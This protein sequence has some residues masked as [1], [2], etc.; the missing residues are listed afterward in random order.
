M[1]NLIKMDLY[2]LVR[3]AS[4]WVILCAA[5]GLAVFSNV[6]TG[7][8]LSAIEE[9]QTEAAKQ[10]GGEEA[11]AMEEAQTDGEKNADG[12]TKAGESAAGE[13]GEAGAEPAE[14]TP[15]ES[16]QKQLGLYVSTPEEWAKT[17]IQAGDLALLNLQSGLLLV[18]CSVLV[19]LFVNAEQKNGYIKNIAGQLKNRGSL[20]VSHMAVTALYLAAVL[21]L[22]VL[23]IFL[24]GRAVF[25]ERLLWEASDSFLMGIFAQYLLHL[26]F[27][28]L[29][30]L[31]GTL[32][33]SSA[34]SMTAG[35]CF[36]CGVGSM[37]YPMLSEQIRKLSGWKS[38]DLMNYLPVENVSVIGWDTAA[39]V[40]YRGC[41]VGIC[42]VLV[43]TASA[44][45]IL[46]KRDVR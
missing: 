25:G 30:L 21:A 1:Y 22:F 43:C 2:R 32:T 35:I 4:T 40:L 45:L 37:V 13:N 19:P 11:T 38:F 17:D 33:R 20:I 18:L 6:M 3:S 28:A 10:A 46:G 16:G 27:C 26:G 44:A 24:S 36:S 41:A 15:E 8:D 14:E 42:F 29:L 9:A 34:F 5:L 12:Q 23:G 39:E 31:L 7:E